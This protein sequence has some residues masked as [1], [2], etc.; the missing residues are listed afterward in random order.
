MCICCSMPTS[1]QEH[2][3]SERNSVQAK[4]WSLF[5]LSFFLEGVCWKTKTKQTIQ[6][7]T[8]SVSRLELRLLMHFCKKEPDVTCAQPISRTVVLRYYLV[9]ELSTNIKHCVHY[10][11]THTHFS[12]VSVSWATQHFT[13]LN[14]LV[15]PIHSLIPPQHTFKDGTTSPAPWLKTDIP[16]GKGF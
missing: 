14:Y 10:R 2:T 12:L 11:V 1:H 16:S 7:F 15:S 5:F 6:V 8:H 13:S 4:E 3:V 9:Y